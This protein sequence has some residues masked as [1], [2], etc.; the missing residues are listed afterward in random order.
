[1]DW[2]EQELKQALNRKEPSPDFAGRVG[3]RISGAESQGGETGPALVPR[4]ARRAM[5][6]SRWRLAT[7]AAFVIAAG[8]AEVGYRQHQGEV[9]RQQVMQA[10][11]MAGARLNHIQTQVREVRR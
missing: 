1:M 2:L 4:G 11:R 3:R 9:A 7:A 10:F 6:S 8:V 5:A